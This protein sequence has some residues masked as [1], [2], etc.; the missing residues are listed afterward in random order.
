MVWKA[1]DAQVSG[2]E[3]LGEIADRGRVRRDGLQHRGGIGGE[4]EAAG[5]GIAIQKI[6]KKSCP[7]VISGRVRPDLN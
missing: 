4:I 7:D 3:G 1:E 5:D 6:C 2:Y